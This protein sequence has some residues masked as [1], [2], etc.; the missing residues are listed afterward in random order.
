MKPDG[1]AKRSS[2]K[3]V[4]GNE[5]GVILAVSLM[6][7]A[8]LAAMGSVTVVMTRADIKV[9]NNYKNSEQAFFVAQA[10]VEH[11]REQLRAI[12]AVSANKNSFSDE[13]AASTGGNA[14]LDGYVSG[15][16][17]LPL[18]SSGTLAKG[19]YTVYLT[20]DITDGIFSTTDTNNTVTL[21]SVGTGPNGSAAVI[22]MT[23]STFAIFTPPSPVTLVGPGATF[24]GNESNA[25]SLHGDD[26]CA[27]DP[28]GFTRPVVTVSHIADL[29]NVQA[30]IAGSKPKRYFTRDSTGA[31]VTA[32]TDPNLISATISSSTL[33]VIFNKY[34]VNL[35][36]AND[37]NEMVQSIEKAADTVAAGGTSSNSVYVCS[38]GDTKVVVV[39]GDFALIDNGAGILVVTGQLTFNGNI[40]FDGMIFVIGEGQMVRD[41]TGTGTIAGGVFVA[42]TI[43]LDGIMYTADDTLGAPLFDT[44]G[45]GVSDLS[46]CST[47]MEQALTD[48]PPRAVAFNHVM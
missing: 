7:M 35:L 24:I 29:P 46:Y 13:L 45:G 28:I 30:N 20:N 12:N 18:I 15:S 26:Q 16:D 17:D 31:E 9:S 34:G 10:G 21:T 47:A 43:G 41:G 27:S 25:K 39:N 14:L 33:T 8:L 37:L 3:L 32:D 11:A 48:I 38:P 4:C 44:S 5:R 19:T 42:N 1:K 36:D 22:E 2:I 23:V 40:D 6:F